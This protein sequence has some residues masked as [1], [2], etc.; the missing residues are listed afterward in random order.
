MS[1]WDGWGW[2]R[3]RKQPAPAN[4]I[5]VKRAG[6][7]TSWW[8]QR[9][10]DALHEVLAGDGNRLARGRTYA[11]AG[12]THDLAVRGGT[13][14]ARVTGSRPT[15]YRIEIRI[16]PLA[17]AVWTRAIG[18][19]ASQAQ[20]AADLLAG[21]MPA[22]IDEAF[23]AAGASLFPR[24][25]SDLVTTCTCPDWGD[26][27]KHVAAAHYVLGDA[28]DRDPFLLFD[29]RGMTQDA[30]L[31]ALR[32]ARSH[33]APASAPPP[34]DAPVAT[35]AT[36]KARPRTGVGTRTRT[37]TDAE[38]AYERTRA[39]TRAR[40]STEAA[41]AASRTTSTTDAKAAARAKPRGRSS[42]AST[43][44]TARTAR[45]ESTE[46]TVAPLAP[47]PD[48]ATI[49]TVAM[50]ATAAEYER[51]RAPLPSLHFHFEAPAAAPAGALLRQLGAP[52]A[53]TEP[54]SPADVLAPV[55]RAAATLARRLA[56]AEV[57]DAP[58]TAP[59]PAPGATTRTRSPR[60]R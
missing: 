52:S 44:R 14:T 33:G 56:I 25:R 35:R 23:D 2:R 21:R 6:A 46:S 31:A 20:F 9:W 7:T 49:A 36:K 11:R 15:P 30:V 58:A 28:F 42:T 10:I 53:W 34:P 45:T 55:V 24:R 4:G 27:C 17:P 43:A 18:H 29:L 26:P 19:M 22:Q 51:P 50:T 60:R 32:A 37:R 1:R 8:A 13:V 47:A 12:R 5:A 48:R 41:H 59:F 40:T 16:P 3:A 57:P 38:A 54:Q 39:T